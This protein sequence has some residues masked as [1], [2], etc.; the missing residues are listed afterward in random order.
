M[1]R[2]NR[3]PQIERL[4]K[5]A[6]LPIVELA[7]P[8]LTYGPDYSNRCAAPDCAEPRMPREAGRGRRRFCQRHQDE[9][10]EAKRAA[11]LAAEKENAA[12]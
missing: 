12:K 3:R 1:P 2:K 11:R 9:H 6:P 7:E 10:M 4:Y 5:P 8:T